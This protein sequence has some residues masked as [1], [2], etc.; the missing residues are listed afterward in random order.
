MRYRPLG[1]TGLEVSEIGLGTWAFASQIYGSVERS[2]AEATV[3]AALDGGVTLFDTAP[4]YGDD[5][6]DGIAETILGEALGAKRER[7]LIASKFGR[8]S[9]DGAAPNFHAQ[10]A[11]ESVEGSLERLGTDRLD[12]LFFH[13][14]FGAGDIRDDVWDELGRLQDEGKVRVI[15]HSISMFEQT[16]H[17]AREWADERRIGAV[18]VV[19]SLMNRQA[20]SLIGDMAEAGVGVFAREVLANG[21]LVGGITAETT[22][23]E[24]HL[25]A[26]Y[27]REEVAERAGYVAALHDLLVSGGAGG[28]GAGKSEAYGPRTL[29]Q[30]AYRWVLDDPAVSLALSGASTPAHLADALSASALPSFSAELHERLRALHPRDFQAA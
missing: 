24:G 21:F 15:G 28:S 18:Q 20:A 7:V 1:T 4:L 6:R 30:A 16:E 29:P 2:E 13:S 19:Y 12:V 11:R 3:R 17:M 9:T 14:P 22:F 26:R 5:E 25:N 27:S 8:Y 23:P 10:R